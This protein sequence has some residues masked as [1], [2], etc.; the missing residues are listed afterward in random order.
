MSRRWQDHLLVIVDCVHPLAIPRNRQRV[1]E[2]LATTLVGLVGLVLIPRHRIR[3]GI[4]GVARRREVSIGP[5]GDATDNGIDHGDIANDDG[6]EGFSTGPASGLGS[7][8]GTGLAELVDYTQ[9]S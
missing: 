7:T 1:T 4:V 2:F 3:Q 9:A 6:D 5:A 8:I